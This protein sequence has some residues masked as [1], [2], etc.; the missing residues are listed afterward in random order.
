MTFDYLTASME[1]SLKE[2]KRNG[3][4]EPGR[5]ASFDYRLGFAMAVVS[6]VKNW[7]KTVALSRFRPLQMQPK[8]GILDQVL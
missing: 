3:S 1:R 8:T 4:V 2:R 6:R 5:S 7:T